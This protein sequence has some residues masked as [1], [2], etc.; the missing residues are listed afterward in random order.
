MLWKLKLPS[1]IKNFAWR[2]L[3]G[4][5]PLKSI[6]VNR[7]IGHSGQCPICLLGPEDISHLL[8]TCPAAQGLWSALGLTDIVQQAVQVDRAG[9]AVLEFLVR[10]HNQAMPA[11]P[12]IKLSEVIVTSCWYLWWIRR[13]RVHNED[14]PPLFK[15]KMSILSIVTNAAKPPRSTGSIDSRWIKPGPRQVKLN[16]DASLKM[17]GQVE[18]VLF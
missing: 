17:R 3:H 8:F 6:L 7:H 11:I 18:R 12:S 5:L 10:D 16:V 13:R 4:L 14:V 1:K 15:C 9:S 2:A